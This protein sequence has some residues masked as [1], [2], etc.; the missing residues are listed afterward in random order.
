MG[1]REKI[2]QGT[3]YCSVQPLSLARRASVSTRFTLFAYISRTTCPAV[4]PST[5]YLTGTSSCL[6]LTPPRS[7]LSGHYYI[8]LCIHDRVV[9]QLHTYTHTQILTHIHTQPHVH[10]YFHTRLLEHDFGGPTHL[11]H[12]SCSLML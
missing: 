10:T 7:L 2:L 9:Y 6:V 11:S 3:G 4:V 12:L 1:G 5:P 8:D